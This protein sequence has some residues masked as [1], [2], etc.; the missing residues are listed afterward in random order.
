MHKKVREDLVIGIAWIGHTLG[1]EYA[2]HK[3]IIKEAIRFKE[4]SKPEVSA[5]ENLQENYPWFELTHL[6]EPIC[7]NERLCKLS[8]GKG[9]HVLL[10]DDY[11]SDLG[12]DITRKAVKEG[13]TIEE[14]NPEYH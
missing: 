1:P 11:Q 5:L 13:I 12:T 7:L 14:L 3:N 6:G 9:V 4:E 10:L 8:S 2:L